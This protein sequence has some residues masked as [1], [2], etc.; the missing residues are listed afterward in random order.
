MGF[1]SAANQWRMAI[2]F[3]PNLIGGVALPILAGLHGA[4][5]HIQYQKTLYYSVL[6]NGCVSFCIAVGVS[7]VS[8]W[9]MLLYGESYGAHFP[10]LIMLSICAVLM[11]VCSV[12][13]QGI[14]SEGRMWAGFSLNAIWGAALVTA[15][16][17]WR[18][19]GAYGL[20]SAN[21]LAYGIHLITIGAYLF[22]RRRRDA[23]E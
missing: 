9:I 18:D 12:I 4:R 7:L 19:R 10:V 15:T 3:L 16:W 5:D 22:S 1:F 11:A 8:P 14:A 6:T 2:L 20:A 23:T 13:G 21:V 17:L